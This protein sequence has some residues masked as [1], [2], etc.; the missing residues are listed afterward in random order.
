MAD[1]KPT[2]VVFV[3]HGQT[4]TTGK[5]LPGRARGLHL[6]DE[7]TIQAEIAAEMIFEAFGTKV[8]AV[9]SSPLERARETAAPIAKTIKCKVQTLEELTEC[10]F[11]RWTGKSL[12][13]LRKLSSWETVQNSPSHFRFPGGESFLEMQ[14]RINAAVL[15]LKDDHRGQVVVAVSHADTIKAAL[16]AALG[17]GLDSFQRITV[18]PAS[19]SVVVYGQ[20]PH[21]ICM[22]STDLRELNPS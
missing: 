3:R 22:N 19:L 17:M 18:S 5:V 12:D 4:P 15:D 20:T 13:R 16:A 1:P 14:A 7:G 6:S 2:T 11:G 10:D 9:Y 8:S 21:V